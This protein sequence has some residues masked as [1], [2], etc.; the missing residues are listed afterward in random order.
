M[1]DSN[2]Q[3]LANILW[4]FATMDVVPPKEL[5]DGAIQRFMD[6]L[7]AYNPQGIA[8]TMWSFASLGYFPGENASDSKHKQV[9]QNLQHTCWGNS[10]SKG[11]FKLMLWVS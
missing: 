7:P 1:A 5:M 10:R 6:L 9:Q 4:A 8:N 2:P 3:N 11:S